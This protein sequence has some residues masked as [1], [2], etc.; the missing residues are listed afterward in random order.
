MMDRHTKSVEDA[1]RRARVTNALTSQEPTLLGRANELRNWINTAHIELSKTFSGV[2]AEGQNGPT[3]STPTSL[4]A[5]VAKAC[6]QAACLV[7]AIRTLN[8]RL[9]V[10]LTDEQCGPSNPPRDN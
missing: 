9:G 2:F 6:E 10:E 5:L 1:V 7:G 8:S 4:D 3:T